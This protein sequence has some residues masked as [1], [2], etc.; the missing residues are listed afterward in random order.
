MKNR[1]QE[2]S[3]MDFKAIPTEVLGRLKG[4]IVFM[5]VEGYIYSVW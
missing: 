3:L 2:C 4:S 5:R 1:S